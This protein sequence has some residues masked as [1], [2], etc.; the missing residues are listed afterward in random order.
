MFTGVY[1]VFI[2]VMLVDLYNTNSLYRR[3]IVT[4]EFENILQSE[5]SMNHD[6]FVIIYRNLFVEMFNWT[7]VNF[8]QDLTL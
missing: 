3:T 7:N 5:L 2:Q 1:S 8:R 6:I 4:I